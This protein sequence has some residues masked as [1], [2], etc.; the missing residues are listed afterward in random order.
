[1]IYYKRGDKKALVMNG[2]KIMA[3]IM[4]WI[5]EK[6]EILGI[7]DKISHCLMHTAYMNG[8]CLKFLK[9]NS[10]KT[11]CMPTGVKNFAVEVQKYTIGA[12]CDFS[13]H[14]LFHI[15]WK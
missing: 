3:F 6:L 12:A 10:V 7:L 13:G 8:S 14:S 2:D 11:S 1:M 5:V 4:M 15:D 9:S